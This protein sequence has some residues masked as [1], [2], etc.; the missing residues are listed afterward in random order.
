[1]DY[2]SICY[3]LKIDIF[4][5]VLGFW[6]SE[7]GSGTVMCS[8]FQVS[9]LNLRYKPRLPVIQKPLGGNFIVYVVMIVVI[10]RFT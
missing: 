10:I 4:I 3:E 2:G 6:S 5:F 1:M 9:L 8:G 7:E